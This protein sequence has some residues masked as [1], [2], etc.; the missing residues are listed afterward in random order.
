MSN[1][2][3]HNKI[4]D[5][6]LLAKR[7][8]YAGCVGLPWLWICNVLYFRMQVFGPCILLDYWPGHSLPPSSSSSAMTGEN[9]DSDENEN[10]NNDELRLERQLQKMELRKWVRRSTTG[11]YIIIPLFV[12]WIVTFQ[13]NKDHFSNKWF[14]MDQTEAEVSGW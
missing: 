1:S 10:D 8:F 4:K 7:M 11:A 3:S 13:V 6:I 14:V 12:A 2:T 9:V 5:D